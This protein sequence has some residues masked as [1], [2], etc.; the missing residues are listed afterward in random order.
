MLLVAS[1]RWAD[2]YAVVE[3]Q[4]LRHVYNQTR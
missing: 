3:E 2:G 1:R 4:T